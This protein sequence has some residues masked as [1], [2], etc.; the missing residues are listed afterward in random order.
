MQQNLFTKHVGLHAVQT[1][2]VIAR[3]LYSMMVLFITHAFS[4]SSLSVL[5]QMLKVFFDYCSSSFS[6]SSSSSSS[7]LSSWNNPVNFDL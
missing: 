3:R 7:S 5:I 1:I 4:F 2:N 6:F